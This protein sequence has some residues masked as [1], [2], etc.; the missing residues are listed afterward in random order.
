MSEFAFIELMKIT[1]HITASRI[2]HWLQVIFLIF[3]FL[4]F[5]TH[6][7]LWGLRGF[8][9]YSGENLDKAPM[10]EHRGLNHEVLGG[11]TWQKRQIIPQAREMSNDKSREHEAQ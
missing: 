2:A 1:N 7:I 11:T 3:A 6:F 5:A 10:L 4:Y 8:K 9:I